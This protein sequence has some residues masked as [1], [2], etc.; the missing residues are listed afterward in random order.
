MH[1]GPSTPRLRTA[2]KPTVRV[3]L[4]SPR[5]TR[6]CQGAGKGL[7]CQPPWLGQDRGVKPHPDPCRSLFIPQLVCHI[8][9]ALPFYL[10]RRLQRRVGALL[11]FFFVARFDPKQR[12]GLGLKQPVLARS[13]VQP[14]R[15]LGPA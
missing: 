11:P 12:A 5:A 7:P 2:T 14:A 1:P 15:A 13:A 4:T 6:S 10:G 8:G 3:P 9:S